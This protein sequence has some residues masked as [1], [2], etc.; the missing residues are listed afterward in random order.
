[1][2][3]SVNKVILI[4]NLTRDPELRYTPQGHAVCSFGI[5]TNREWV[6]NGEKQE[7]ADFHNVVA[8]N[9]LA[10]I[11]AQLLSKGA[12]AYVEGRLQTRSWEGDDG[13]KRYKTEII[14][15][16]MVVLTFK[17]GGAGK[18]FSDSDTSQETPEDKTEGSKDKK[19][20]EKGDLPAQEGKSEDVSSED[21]PF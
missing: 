5:A 12:K 4:G 6:S 16:E 20:K 1:M 11:C 15:D 18:S 19:T 13:V 3:R 17:D 8:W 2:A 7:A 14:I 10:E 9:K 21:I